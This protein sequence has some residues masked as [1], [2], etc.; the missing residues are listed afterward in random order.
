MA[1]AVTT[2]NSTSP[3]GSAS[4]HATSPSNSMSPSNAT[5]TSRSTSSS[6]P[7]SSQSPRDVW[8]DGLGRAGM[9][10]LQVLLILTLVVVGIYGLLQI[11][12]LVIPVVIALILAAAIGPFVNMLRRRGWRG[13][14][15][16]GVAFVALLLLLAAVI[17]IIILSVR[18]QWED[19]FSR[20]ASGLDE[21][22][23]F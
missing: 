17:A 19:L 14:V 1:R 22:E 6:T 13:G 3:S 20:A 10:S 16:T 23:S 12:L 11:R 8:S 9:R 15:A 21:L 7:S 4:P 18:N 5:S 2:S